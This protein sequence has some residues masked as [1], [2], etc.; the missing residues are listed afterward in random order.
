M[1][2]LLIDWRS[3][4]LPLKPPL[5]KFYNSTSLNMFS[6]NIVKIRQHTLKIESWYQKWSFTVCKMLVNASFT[7][8]Q[9]FIGSVPELNADFSVQEDRRPK[10]CDNSQ[11]RTKLNEALKLKKL[12]LIYMAQLKKFWGCRDHTQNLTVLGGLCYPPWPSHRDLSMYTLRT[13]WCTA[14]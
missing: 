5:S 14:D 2:I 10:K 8:L 13:R 3:E 12:C 1:K 9:V 4:L 6:T 11:G 7:S